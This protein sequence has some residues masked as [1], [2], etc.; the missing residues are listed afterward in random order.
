MD[1]KSQG[2]FNGKIFV[3]PDAQKTDAKQT[4]R[5]LLLS[6]EAT[7]NTKPQLEFLRMT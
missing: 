6:N 5:N 1:G 3:R 4:N 2:V 7:I